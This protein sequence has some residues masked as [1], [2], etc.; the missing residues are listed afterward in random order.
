[1]KR[2]L[3]FLVPVFFCCFVTSSLA[4]DKTLKLSIQ[5]ALD[6]SKVQEVLNQD[7]AMYWGE[8]KSPAVEKEY[9][10]YKTSQRSNAFRKSKEDAC[11]WALASALKI[12]QQRVSKEG[13]NALINLQSN[14]KNSPF[15][16]DT[17]FECLA[18]SMMVNVAVKG[19]VVKLAK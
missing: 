19:T 2:K 13:G 1:M 16:S 7:I 3:L 10:E 14:I 12:M 9:G 8:Q 11:R 5:E 17:E 6:D 18:G 15:S 4:V